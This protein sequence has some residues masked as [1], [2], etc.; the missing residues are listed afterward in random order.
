MNAQTRYNKNACC[1]FPESWDPWV[2][3]EKEFS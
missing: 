1:K 3:T 2:S